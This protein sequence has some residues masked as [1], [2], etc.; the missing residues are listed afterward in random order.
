M[1]RRDVRIGVVTS[2]EN[3]F[4]EL[5]ELAKSFNIELEQLKGEKIEIQ[6]DNLEEISKTAAY[7]AYLTF[8]RPLI[9]DDSGL[10]IETLQNFPGPYTNFVKNTIGLKGILKLLEDLKDRSA[11]FMTV[12]TFTDG[13]IIKTF[14]GIV[15]GVISEEIRGNSG[16]GFDPIFIP[17]GEKRTFAEM[18]LEEKNKYSH[19]ARAFAKFADFL[20][21]YL[22]KA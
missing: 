6:S 9:V 11:Y 2:N 10:F 12:L 22:E 21:S 4:M 13:K 17:E 18:S 1:L 7:L 14:N 8:R 3:K 15:K 16:F 5:K 20:M 19:R